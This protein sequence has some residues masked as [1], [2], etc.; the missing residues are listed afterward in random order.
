MPRWDTGQ[1]GLLTDP[2]RRGARWGGLHSS[3]DY[4][5]VFRLSQVLVDARNATA[6][7]PEAV[8]A[9]N[10]PVGASWIVKG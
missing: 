10:G 3:L 6:Q 8:G 9:A 5:R 2:L 1:G 4:A 7:G